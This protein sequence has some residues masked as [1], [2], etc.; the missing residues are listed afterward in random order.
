MSGWKR[1]RHD[2]AAKV[3]ASRVF[4][5]VVGWVSGVGLH[6]I[7]CGFKAYR[8]E[9]VRELHLYGGLHRYVPVLA[10]ARGYRCGEIEIEHRPRTAGQTKYGAGRLVTGFLDLLTVLLLTRFASRP[11]HLLGGAGLVAFVVGIAV[12]LAEL[13]LTLIDWHPL[14]LGP[15]RLL[16]GALL[17]LLGLELIA[18][19]LIGELVVS[20]QRRPG[21]AYSVAERLG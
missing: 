16:F 17:I 13:L 6:D 8:A 12:S 19:G 7:N 18:L 4:N 2:P 11:L 1:E 10:Q 3:F 21:D 14:R 20:R 9:L 5:A 15:H